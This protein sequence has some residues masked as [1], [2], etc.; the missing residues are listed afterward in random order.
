MLRTIAGAAVLSFALALSTGDA[1]AQ[2]PLRI[3]A[4]PTIANV[5]TDDWDT[6]SKVGFFVAAGTAFELQ[7]GLAVTPYLAFVKKGATFNATAS[8]SEGDGSYD[9]IEIPVLLSKQIPFGETKSIGLSLGPQVAFNINCDED[10][11][12][13]SEY[14]DFKSTEFGLVGG[15][16]LGFPLG[17]AHTASVG[18][19]FDFGLTDVFESE[20]GYKNRVIYLWGS[21]GTTIGG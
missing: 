14:E 4:G 13:C 5:S 17:E 16:G 21:V 1:Q 6:S 8:E 19:S 2:I 12:D 9:Y 20:N 11:Y 3:V 10:G 18:V 7:D 15:A